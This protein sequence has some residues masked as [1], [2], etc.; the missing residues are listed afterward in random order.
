VSGPKPNMAFECSKPFAMSPSWAAFD[1]GQRDSP[2]SSDV[3]HLKACDFCRS[4]RDLKQSAP[5]V[6]KIGRTSDNSSTPRAQ[7]QKETRPS[8]STLSGSC[9]E[10]QLC[11]LKDSLCQRSQG[12]PPTFIMLH[13]HHRPIKLNPE[14]GKRSGG[15]LPTEPPR[16]QAMVNHSPML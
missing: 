4:A 2:A 11:T 14:L 10:S 16:F 8:A 3:H 1:G 7:A 12:T 5:E 6:A 9:L 13:R 15:A